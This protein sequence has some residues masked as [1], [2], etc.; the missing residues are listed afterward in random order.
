ML[1]AAAYA[2]VLLAAA[3]LGRGAPGPHF[4]IAAATLLLLC[5]GIHNAWD[6]V[7]YLTVNVLR[8]VVPKGENEPPPR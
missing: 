8:T 1:P 3:L 5:V 2:A 7:T 4:V 6:T